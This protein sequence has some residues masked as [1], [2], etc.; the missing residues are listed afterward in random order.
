[1][2]LFTVQKDEHKTIQIKESGDYTVELQGSGAHADIH[3]TF[4]ATGK[5]H[6]E[7]NLYI[8]HTAPHTSAQ[9]VLKGVAKDQSTLRFFG[10]I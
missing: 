6:L 4:L 10:R 3:G 5:D 8:L 7:V 1:M 2:T 9:T